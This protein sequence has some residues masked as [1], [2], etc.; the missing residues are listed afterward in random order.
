MDCLNKPEPLIVKSGN[1]SAAWERFEEQLEWFLTAKGIPNDAAHSEQ[2][3][4]TL[5]NVGKTEAQELYRTFKWKPAADGQPAE[6]KKDYE[7]VKRKFRDYCCPLKNE[8]LESFAF[9][10]RDQGESESFDSFLTDLR[11]KAATCGYET[12]TDRMI[13]DRIVHGIFD[14]GVQ[15]KLLRQEGKLSLDKAI[16]ICK[17]AELSKLGSEQ[18]NPKEATSVHAVEK[19]KK[20][21]LPHPVQS[22]NHDQKIEKRTQPKVYDCKRCG[23]AHA[24]RRCPAWTSTCQKCNKKGHF[25]KCCFAKINIVTENEEYEMGDDVFFVGTVDA[26]KV[27][28]AQKDVEVR[29]VQVDMRNKWQ[30]LV[31]FQDGN[32]SK[33]INVKLDTGAGANL[34]AWKDYCSI[35][36]RPKLK[37]A[38]VVL[39][40]YNN[41]LIATHGSC[42]AR[43]NVRGQSVPVRFAVVENSQSLL[44]GD[45]CEKLGL[46][47]K[48]DG[49]ACQNIESEDDCT[50]P[51]VNI[52]PSLPFEY[53]IRV[54]PSVTPV[55]KPPRR[56]PVCI[57]DSLKSELDRMEAIGVIEK[58]TEP[59][60]WV[61]EIVCVRKPNGKL[62][63]CLDPG[64]LNK[65]VLREHYQLP[66]REEIFSDI[67]EATVFS[68]LDASQ[69]FWQIP[70]SENTKTLTC[71]NTP[72]GRYVYRRLPYGLASSPEVFHRSMELMFGDVDG[73]K[74]YMDDI[75][76]W[77]KDREQ[78]DERLAKV[79][80]RIE[81]YGLSM[82]WEKCQFNQKHVTFIGE[83]LSSEGVRPDDQKLDAIK[84]METPDNKEALRRALGLINYVGRFIPSLATQ[85]SNLRQL[86]KDS[87]EWCWGPEHDK[88]WAQLK[89][90]MASKPVLAYF[91]PEKSTKISTDA[92]KDGLGAVLLQKQQSGNWL[93]VAYAA[94]SMSSAEK[95]Y[96]Q[97]EK[98]CL[99]MV[100]GCHKF[101]QY[102]YGIKQL[103]L[104]TDHKP[105]IS[106]AH[107]PL[108]E[109]T[110][111]LQRLMLKLQRYQFKIEW[112]PGKY[113]VVAD[114]LS[115]C[116]NYVDVNSIECEQELQAQTD[117]LSQSLPVT[118]SKL[119]EIVNETA[120]DPVLGALK[121]C[122][123]EGWPK[124]KCPAFDNYKEDLCLVNGLI[125]KGNKIVIPSRFRQEMLNRLH[126]GHLGAEKQKRLAR[127][128]IYW[129]GINKD[130]DKMCEKCDV[131]VKFRPSQ[132]R[133]T[134]KSENECY[135]PWEK[136]G[137]DLFSWGGNNYLIV[138]DYY[139]NFPEVAK[140]SVPNTSNIVTQLKS[141]FARHGVPKVL[142][143]D[144]GPQYASM[145][146]RN[147][148]NAWGIEHKTSS[149]YFAQ[150]NGKAE[151]GVGI[152]KALLN[153]AK[154][155]NEDPY[156]SLMAYRAAPME[157]GWSPA[158]LLMGRR[159]NVGLPNYQL[160]KRTYTH[161]EKYEL[162][163]KSM[164]RYNSHAR[165][166]TSLSEG[167]SVRVQDPSTKRWTTSATVLKKVAPRS[168]DVITS[169]GV[170]QRRNRRALV[171]HNDNQGNLN[172]CV[173]DE[174]TVEDSNS[175]NDNLTIPA[176]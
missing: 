62:R 39:R 16:T 161:H 122:I 140:L 34:L 20:T 137:S 71:F 115:R 7:T 120:Q 105:L 56:V 119:T 5:L 100:Y 37:T 91:D 66:T 63:V 139:S 2:R 43:V 117:L 138:V 143:S 96:A 42:V 160:R 67:K 95:H 35:Q 146:F 110:P 86:L 141:M 156:K 31:P 19:E 21:E 171:K 131:C 109:L 158:E 33:L 49:V 6:D 8:V 50:L 14:K 54:D 101:H 65:A 113:L 124:G 17:A 29:A 73:C 142:F 97:I 77:G 175:D 53:E 123:V 163:H 121:N 68:K 104:E 94:R 64:E 15:Q 126:M 85:C 41:G 92:S 59:T 148:M 22:E 134:Y 52:M 36:A 55:I 159:I 133:E 76:V 154:E 167:E 108:N 88:E 151:R 103:E 89:E 23:T 125:M 107:K 174:R 98:E 40:D 81:K 135:G 102:V 112:C 79:R 157:S 118:D 61:S 26:V 70:L 147:F 32:Q 162:E 168:Y 170:R 18:L 111:R 46:V 166:L 130:I 4:A 127:T 164:K 47:Q 83:S 172:E 150:S 93:P 80:N 149:P 106:L 1:V 116:V 132:G 24:W 144:N 74:V 169:D 9:N 176:K 128:A 72:F 38:H 58:Q 12:Q 57:K 75:L 48:I 84:R 153:K 28:V 11:L 25:T 69:A 44:G 30:C 3:T 60:K 10:R 129:P 87:V 99:G 27:E 136:V 78:H 152:I 45:T 51:E 82:N 173:E 155:A 145:E 114:V 13:R 165:D 90:I